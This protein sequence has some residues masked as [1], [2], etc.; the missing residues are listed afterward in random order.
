[1]KKECFWNFIRLQMKLPA[2][3]FEHVNLN[4][5][6]KDQKSQKNERNYFPPPCPRASI[7]ANATHFTQS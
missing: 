7:F 5:N 1:M 6:S 3:S 4:Q 2:V